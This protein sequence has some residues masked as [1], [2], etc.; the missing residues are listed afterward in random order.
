MGNKWHALLARDFWYWKQIFFL[1]IP[2]N[3]SME[4]RTTY[5]LFIAL[6]NKRENITILS[7]FFFWCSD[8]VNQNK[9]GINSRAG[10]KKKYYG[11]RV[12]YV[13]SDDLMKQARAQSPLFFKGP[14]KKNVYFFGYMLH[15]TVNNV[16]VVSWIADRNEKQTT[17]F[18]FQTASLYW[19][20]RT[21]PWWSYESIFSPGYALNRTCIR[22]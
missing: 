19:L 16:R 14:F 9:Y 11:P 8:C 2:P 21:Y 15:K 17:E 12:A 5:L 4:D 7:I 13:P 18:E 20:Q 10:I 1:F 3:S 22:K 6:N